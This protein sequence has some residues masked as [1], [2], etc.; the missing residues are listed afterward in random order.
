MRFELIPSKFKIFRKYLIWSLYHM[1]LEMKLL[2]LTY[3]SRTKSASFKMFWTYLA[4]SQTSK[5]L[6]II[7][8]FIFYHKILAK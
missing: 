2:Y 5:I 3:T 8:L 1:L 7:Y 4:L 6:T